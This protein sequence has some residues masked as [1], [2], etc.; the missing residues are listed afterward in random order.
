MGTALPSVTRKF[1]LI[2]AVVQKRKINSRVAFVV[3][4]NMLKIK[5]LVMHKGN[6]CEKV[7]TYMSLTEQY[8]KEQGNKSAF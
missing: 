3:C 8:Q 2:A 6:N 7:E 5:E 1:H 4:T